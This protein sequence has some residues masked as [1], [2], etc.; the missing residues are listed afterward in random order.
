MQKQRCA[1][2][3]STKEWQSTGTGNTLSQQETEIQLTVARTRRDGQE[4]RIQPGGYLK[5]GGKQIRQQQ[6]QQEKYG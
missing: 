6:Q 3:A 2:R 4:P 1:E 5:I